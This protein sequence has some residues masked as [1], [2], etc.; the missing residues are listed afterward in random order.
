MSSLLAILAV[1][2]L[3]FPAAL[4]YSEEGARGASTPDW[5]RATAWSARLLGLALAGRSRE[6]LSLVE[7]LDQPFGP[8][9]LD[10]LVARGIVRLWTDDLVG[11]QADLTLAVEKTDACQPLGVS[12][13]IGFLAQAAFRSG[14]LQDAVDY[15]ELAVTMAFEADRVWELPML[16]AFAALP[17]AARGEF[18]D[19]ERHVAAASQWAELMGTGWA[20]ACVSA[21]RAHLAQARDDVPALYRAAVDFTAAYGLLEPGFHVLGPVLAQALVGLGQLDEAVPALADFER[22]VLSTGGRSAGASVAKVKGQLFAARGDWK[23]AE[24]QFAEAVHTYNELAMPLGSG[25]AHLAWG[26]AALR[27]GKRKMA[28]RELVAA[29]DLLRGA[30]RSRYASQADRSLEKL[31]MSGA[32][33]LISPGLLTPTEEAVV[34]VATSGHSNAEIAKRLA[35]SVKTVEYHLTHVYAKLGISSRRDLAGR[36]SVVEVEQVGQGAEA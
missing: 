25:L 22:N 34:R 12:Y 30:R 18:A 7:H 21:A 24:A 19:A 10:A 29:R 28:A 31:G 17:R 16:H 20:R 6:A 9:G 3:D 8:R 11:A 26:G 15:G 35:V 2:Q 33:S 4:H 14:R 5:A 1:V 13:A 27:T 32:G 36:L 23:S